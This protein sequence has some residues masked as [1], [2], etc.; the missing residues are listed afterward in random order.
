MS[1]IDNSS[2]P[3]PASTD[4]MAAKFFA[5][6]IGL[7]DAF[8]QARSEAQA[9]ERAALRRLIAWTPINVS[10][11]EDGRYRYAG[12]SI[13]SYTR[14]AEIHRREL[15]RRIDELPSD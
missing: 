11:R 1:I 8:A 4:P 14:G 10:V 9:A 6:R 7:N 3:E 2:S 15:L 13:S 5:G 12:G